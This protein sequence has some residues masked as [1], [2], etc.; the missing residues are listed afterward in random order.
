MSEK[1]YLMRETY[2]A[3]PTCE[4]FVFHTHR[5]YEIYL[6]LE[7]DVKFIVEDKTYSLE[8]YDVV[9]AKK[10]EL[11]NISLVRDI[12]YHRFVLQ[13]WPSFFEE[14]N[15]PEYEKFFLDTTSAA[16]YK[17]PAKVVRSS[18][19]YD[20]FKKYRKYSDNYKLKDTPVLKAIITEI[21]YL[22]NNINQFATA[23][24]TNTPVE[25]I[26]SYLNE[27]Y[28]ED[29]SME[30]LQNQFFLSRN[31][32]CKIF[33]A[34]TG[35]TV[36]DYIRKKRLALVDDL[37]NEGMTISDASRMAGFHEYSSFYRA[38]MREYGIS[39]RHFLKQ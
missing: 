33:K 32:L 15:C 35:L 20:A 18:G 31:Y 10:N 7:G 34:T 9:I 5:R 8:P 29:I 22:L 6:F 16:E 26:I 19:L 37:T 14:N 27:H 30:L 38:Y 25:R 28:T 23:N 36:F 24:Y 1:Q 39:P 21:L 13:V 2:T 11:H 3:V 12:P 17:I 4:K